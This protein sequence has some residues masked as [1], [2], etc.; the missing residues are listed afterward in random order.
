M[1]M[2]SYTLLYVHL[3]PMCSAALVYDND[4]DSFHD[5][6]GLTIL[7]H[8]NLTRRSVVFAYLKIDLDQYD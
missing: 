7:T 2:R 8:L 4:G 3:E 1:Y 5:Q 6:D